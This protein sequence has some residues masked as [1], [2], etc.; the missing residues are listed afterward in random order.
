MSCWCKAAGKIK[1]FHPG[2]EGKKKNILCK[3]ENSNKLFPKSNS[4]QV[5]RL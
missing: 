4:R 3:K 5:K 2:S 1:S